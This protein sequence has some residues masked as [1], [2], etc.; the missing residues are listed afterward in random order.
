MTKTEDDGLF[1]CDKCGES[2][3]PD[4]F[5]SIG[6]KDHNDTLCDPTMAMTGNWEQICWK[7]EVKKP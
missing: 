1:V 5:A 6:P 7:C 2:D 4:G 3:T